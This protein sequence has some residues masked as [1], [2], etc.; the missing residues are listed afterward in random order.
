MSG[1]SKGNN[2]NFDGKDGSPFITTAQAASMLK[3]SP[4]TLEKMRQR[5]I[6]PKYFK[7][8]NRAYYTRKTISFWSDSKVRNATFDPPDGGLESGG[9]PEREVP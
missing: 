7:I 5:G 1:G 8:L 2:G 3:L 6:G 9:D 4:R